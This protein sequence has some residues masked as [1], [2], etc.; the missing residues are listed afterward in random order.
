LIV[1][2]SIFN[3]ACVFKFVSLNFHRKSKQQNKKKQKT[4]KKTTK[5]K[6]KQKKTT[7]LL[8]QF[9]FLFDI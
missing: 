2:Q 5:N 3:S 1:S 6:A 9:L 8:L 7:K 4:K